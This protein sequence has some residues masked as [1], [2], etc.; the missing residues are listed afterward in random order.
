MIG[1]GKRVD[2][3]FDSAVK[4]VKQLL[5]EK[6]FGVI[7]EIDVKKTVKEKIGKDFDSYVILGACNSELSSRVLEINREFGL[8]MPCNVI[9]YEKDGDTYVSAMRPTKFAE[10]FGND[11]IME[12]A[13][14]V[15]KK[16][17]E[18]VDAV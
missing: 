3:D 5:G 7:C 12:I 14:Y 10:E 6:G 2:L 15:E 16:L 13:E 1:Y 8:L 18:V 9:V 17:R 11:E 4:K